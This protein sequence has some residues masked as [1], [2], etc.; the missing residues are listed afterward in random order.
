M[1][2]A[3]GARDLRAYL[4]GS[5]VLHGGGA[6]HGL[7]VARGQTPRQERLHPS[8]T[9][10]LCVARRATRP[11]CRVSGTSGRGC[12]THGT[13]QN[14]WS[15]DGDVAGAGERAGALDGLAQHRRGRGSRQC[16][17]SPG[18][19]RSRGRPGSS[20][21][22]AASWKPF[23]GGPSP[24]SH[25]HNKDMEAKA[26]NMF[27]AYNHCVY[28]RIPTYEDPNTSQFGIRCCHMNT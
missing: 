24:W 15:V 2:R 17:G 6:I 25:G 21:A 11:A 12:R 9:A 4:P 10:A 13:V 22:G 16:A 14:G 19:R 28:D 3:R 23:N 18:S 7:R 26:K 8:W 20:T 27:T 1:Y 5:D